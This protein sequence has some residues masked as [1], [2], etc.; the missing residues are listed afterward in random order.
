MIS[1]V[2]KIISKLETRLF[3]AALG[4][5]LQH[6]GGFAQCSM[7]SSHVVAHGLLLTAVCKFCSST[8]WISLPRGMWDL[9]SPT[10]DQTHVS[11]IARQ[12]LNHWTTREVSLETTLHCESPT[13]Q[14]RLNGKL[15]K[16]LYFVSNSCVPKPVIPLWPFLISVG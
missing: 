15:G 3:F 9:S 7:Q 14:N 10:R 11:Y 16:L 4:S 2:R 8:A 12:I 1:T 5:L 6:M 13:S